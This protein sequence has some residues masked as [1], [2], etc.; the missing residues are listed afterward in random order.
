[1]EGWGSYCLALYLFY[2]KIYLRGIL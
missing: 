2:A 1:V